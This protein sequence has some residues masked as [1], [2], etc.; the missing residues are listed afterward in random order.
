[1]FPNVVQQN[2]RQGRYDREAQT[3]SQK[4]S[5]TGRF[6]Q[7]TATF[8]APG[9]L[10]EP[11]HPN[12]GT[13]QATQA[14]L[15]APSQANGFDPFVATQL[16]SPA[17]LSPIQSSTSL[18]P[19][20]MQEDSYLQQ[21]QPKMW[22]NQ[23]QPRDGRHQQQIVN[24]TQPHHRQK[25]LDC[26]LARKNGQQQWAAHHQL[27]SMD[28][29]R[30]R[31][32]SPRGSTTS[33][34]QLTPQQTPNQ[35]LNA[36][37]VNC[38]PL[39]AIY[40]R[41]QN[42][43]DLGFIDTTQQF[44]QQQPATPISTAVATLPSP[45]A[46]PNRMICA[47]KRVSQIP[48]ILPPQYKAA[49]SIHG[50]VARQNEVA[51][52]VRLETEQKKRAERYKKR[53]E[54]LKKDASA[55]YHSYSEVLEYFPLDRGAH[56]SPY[57]AGLLANQPMPAEPTSDRGLAIRHAKRNWRNY[58][59]M[60]DLDYVANIAKEEHERKMEERTQLMKTTPPAAR[61]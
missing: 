14:I 23:D 60:K 27:H 19:N 6:A 17:R 4:P 29:Q 38:K 21:W 35:V 3:P 55:I 49:A 5:Q 28:I 13:G 47:P 7:S 1:M 11:F 61:R 52:L 41:L 24:V 26:D 12:A 58:W 22:Q 15:F 40:P 53:R 36:T 8:H 56:C 50:D 18:R 54:E 16:D 42:S 44:G 43:M 57:L 2:P 32:D 31:I 51:E 33:L 48:N 46:T 25:S 45:Q 30:R 9:L 59:E 10:M 34:R 39:M 37:N 20:I